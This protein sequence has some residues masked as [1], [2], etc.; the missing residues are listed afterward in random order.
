M[1]NSCELLLSGG[2]AIF[3]LYLRINLFEY[4]PIENFKSSFDLII[5][6]S[7]ARL[8]QVSFTLFFLMKDLGDSDQ[9]YY[10][11]IAISLI[12]YPI[13]IHII[14]VFIN[15]ETASFLM[16]E[17]ML[18]FI[19]ISTVKITIYVLL[20]CT[21]ILFESTDKKSKLLHKI[22]SISKIFIMKAEFTIITECE[23]CC[24]LFEPSDKIC[25]LSCGHYYHASCH[26]STTEFCLI[27][28][29]QD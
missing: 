20:I 11:K 22:T 1:I 6:L 21:W 13:L 14:L 9:N 2:L 23:M 28:N 4:Q 12:E 17:A 27:C 5:G 10:F 26:A 16:N 29:Q 15:N 7:F 25:I 24:D 19:I 8:I 18:I 3:F